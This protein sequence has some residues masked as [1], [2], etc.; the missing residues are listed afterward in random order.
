MVR[1]F[2]K[3][4]CN[5]AISAPLQSFISSIAN[6]SKVFARGITIGKEF[7]PY[8][9]PLRRPFWETAGE[10]PRKNNKVFLEDPRVD[11][12]MLPLFDGITQIK[13]KKEH[14]DKISAW[15]CLRLAITWGRALGINGWVRVNGRQASVQAAMAF[16]FAYLS[17]RVI[18]ESVF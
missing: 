5:A 10:A 16:W 1:N 9:E 18:F 13:W 14:L 11:T 17:R 15:S 7:N 4:A 12:L 8:L 6:N 2:S 3:R